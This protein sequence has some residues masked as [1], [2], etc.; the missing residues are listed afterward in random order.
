VGP[1]SRVQDHTVSKV[2][3]AVK[4]LNKGTLMIG[5]EEPNTQAEFPRP[6]LD[7]L[8]KLVKGEISI[9]LAWTPAELV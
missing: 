1:C 7:P 2:N 8:L 6:A 4:V 3:K 9:V 5:A